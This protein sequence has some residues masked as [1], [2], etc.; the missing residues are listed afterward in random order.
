MF[1]LFFRVIEG[2]MLWLNVYFMEWPKEYM[3][4][5][6]NAPIALAGGHLA[7]TM[8]INAF[9]ADISKPNQRSFRMAMLYFFSSLSRPFGTQMGKCLFLEG[10]YVCVIGVSVLG[11]IMGFVFLVIR[12]EMFNWKPVKKEDDDAEN[13]TQP[14]RKKHHALSPKH[15]L[16]SINTA[17]KARPN[18]K[19]FYLWVYLLIHVVLILPWGGEG[20]I[21]YN[22]VMTRYNWG[23]KE[24]SDYKTVAEVI[25]I[26]GH[27]IFIP[28]LG[29]LQIRDS[30]LIP[31][32]LTTIIARSFVNA[33]AEQSWMYYFGTAIM[34][35]G[36][37][38]FSV[39][40]SIVSNC[41]EPDELGKVF[42]L[43]S[44]ME[45]L[46]PIGM[47]QVYA[48]LWAA[49]GDLGTPW[50]GSSFMVSGAITCCALLLSVFSLIT[51]KG[52]S[53]S[54]LDDTPI[55]RPFYRLV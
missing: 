7:F 33:F 18:N 5:S 29:Y 31:F 23:V 38:S 17:C 24:Y 15:I 4:F 14:M 41:V 48:S 54:E 42:A 3:L 27:T 9:I 2:S 37:Y 26:I 6:V 35:M 55:S 20:V 21:S 1:V 44:S 12:L 49:T 30:L 39:A 51:L 16:D 45:S 40:R 43:L 34:I 47:S 11:R 52:N 8:G 25:D 13:K 32:L 36:G 53:I 22:Y 19:R 46:L 50:V 10:G 28:L